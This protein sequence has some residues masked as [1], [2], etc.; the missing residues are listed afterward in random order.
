MSAGRSNR[1]DSLKL[2]AVKHGITYVFVGG[3]KRGFITETP[4]GKWRYGGKDYADRDGALDALLDSK[5]FGV[6]YRGNHGQ[7]TRMG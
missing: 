6:M 2:Y 5:G 4:A 7:T 3:I 1:P